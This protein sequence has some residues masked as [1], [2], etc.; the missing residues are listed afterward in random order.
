MV[1][2]VGRGGDL[3]GVV[4]VSSELAGVCGGMVIGGLDV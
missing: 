4:R 2:G 3:V 1:E